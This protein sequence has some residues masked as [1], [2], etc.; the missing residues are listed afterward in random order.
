[1]VSLLKGWLGWALGAIA[2]GVAVVAGLVAT[3]EDPAPQDPPEVAATDT[4]DAPEVDAP[5]T[6]QAEAQPVAEPEGPAPATTA[7]VLT[8]L[9]VTDDGVT[10]SGTADPGTTVQ[11]HVDGD[12]VG[13]A[14][15]DENGAFTAVIDL[16]R[17]AEPRD[18]RLAALPEGDG[19]PVYSDTTVIEPS[20]EPA[21]S[22]AQ[23]VTEEA[24][25]DTP[26]PPVFGNIRFPAKGTAV[27]AGQAGPGDEV[28][29]FL[30]GEEVAAVTANSAGDFAALFDLALSGVPRV[31]RMAIR[32]AEGDLIYAEDSR[33]VEPRAPVQVA[34]AEEAPQA[35]L[36]MAEAASTR[37]PGQPSNPVEVAQA[38]ETPGAEV[39]TP[40]VSETPAPEAQPAETGAPSP[41]TAP[42][43]VVADA[44]ETVAPT[45]GTAQDNDTPVTEQATA[46]EATPESD[47]AGTEQTETAEVS[48]PEP[49]P[50]VDVTPSVP[51]TQETPADTGT[52]MAAADTATPDPEP[53]PTPEADLPPRV[54]RADRDGIR[55]IEEV[56]P[57]DMPDLSL[58]AI[59]YD[60]DGQVTIS[61][62]GEG[63]AQVRL[64][65]DNA[66]VGD[67]TVGP[68]GQWRLTLPESVEPGVYTMRV[69][70]IGADGGVTARVESPFKRED[71]EMLMAALGQSG[72]TPDAEA[73]APD[74]PEPD[75]APEAET[76][77]ASSAP[78]P[79]P[80]AARDSPDPA[81]PPAD[82]EDPQVAEAPTPD[83]AAPP[84][85]ADETP[86]AGDPA[87]PEPDTAAT[88]MAEVDD[89]PQVVDTAP[90]VQEV[91]ADPEPPAAEPMISAIT[92]QPGST[93]WAISRE[94]YGDGLL[95]VQVFQANRDKIRDPD[96]IYPGQVFTLPDDVEPR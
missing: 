86:L 8:A 59:A 21:P 66:A 1:M 45:T 69:D 64:Y 19:D 62:R 44:Q 5:E 18:L 56:R 67:A 28:V 42:E 30:D 4:P 96:L 60:D 36:T 38:P 91:A 74:A 15:A 80:D 76:A 37:A 14:A 27:V 13:E 17:S 6:P 82:P 85:D 54:L 20:A 77:G 73:K 24:A 35:P 78:T 41:D 32:P 58:D 43:R 10:I 93:L 70:E 40:D 90:A 87:A 94:R 50:A 55:V 22:E 25:P 29:I 53:A 89:Q 63:G 68:D 88:D 33:I 11:V 39:Q 52:Q 16:P 49:A 65:L 23:D 81:T 84:P 2:A 47:E 95:Y 48:E 71:P 72:E 75:P 9:N 3:M 46:P 51:E 34:Q 31:V 26:T 12:V 92:V 83:P 7:P 57:A 61:G 79:E